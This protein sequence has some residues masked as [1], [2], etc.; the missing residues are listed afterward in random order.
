MDSLG[1][2][3]AALQALLYP[4]VKSIGRVMYLGVGLAAG[5]LVFCWGLGWHNI[6]EIKKK[7][8]LVAERKAGSVGEGYGAEEKVTKI[9]ALSTQR[10]HNPRSW[11][12]LEYSI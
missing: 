4:Y 1:L 3:G 8:V 2:S 9:Y 10:I 5:A 11:H 6:L 7:E 12:A